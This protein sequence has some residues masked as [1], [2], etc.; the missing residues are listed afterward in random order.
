[1]LTNTAVADTVLVD[2]DFESYADSAALSSV[3]SGTGSSALVDE[4]YETLIDDTF[5]NVAIGA[6]AY[7]T[8]GQGV[9]HLGS[10]FLEYQLP[11][12]G[13]S[14]LAPSATQS[15]VLQGDIFDV[16]A[17]GNKRMSIGLRSN[18][19]ENLIELGH[20][21][22]S[23][24]EF[25]HR[26][27]LFPGDDPD[28][29]PYELD[30]ALDREDDEDD[31]TTLADIGEDWHTHRVTITP[32]TLTYELDLRRDGLNNATGEA[33]VDATVTYDVTTGPNGY[34][35]LRIGSPSG[36]S[37]AGN[38]LYGGVFFDNISLTLVDVVAGPPTGDYNGD[39]FVDAADYTIWRDTLGTVVTAGEGADGN[40]NG[41]V[42]PGDY[43]E[44]ANNYGAGTPVAAFAAAIPEPTT[45]LLLVVGVC[46]GGLRVRR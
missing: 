43:D 41:V 31:V 26:A 27:V 28:W 8:P 42:D 25:S 19:P 36:V 4:T 45:S 3:W 22:S 35:S 38:G 10:G 37:S 21:N 24:V 34:D 14:L 30:P 15:I 2:E 32:D 5:E 46:L 6:R 13:G 29:Q 20:W 7:D 16:G 9:E 40:G 39:G 44:W 11:L 12:N 1:M 33:G 17:F 23:A 18:A